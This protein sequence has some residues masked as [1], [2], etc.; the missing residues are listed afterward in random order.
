VRIATSRLLEVTPELVDRESTEALV[1]MHISD[2]RWRTTGTYD[3]MVHDINNP[4]PERSVGNGRVLLAKYVESCILIQYSYRNNWSK[5]PMM[6]GGRVVK[7]LCI[8]TASG[9]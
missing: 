1:T 9:L 6:M 8:M 3:T 2:V 4:K 5:M 7:Q